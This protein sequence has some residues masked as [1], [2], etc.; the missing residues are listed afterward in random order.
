MQSRIGRGVIIA[1]VSGLAL[2]ASIVGA[3]VVG[4][5]D[6]RDALATPIGA[7]V[8]DLSSTGAYTDYGRPMLSSI[9][10][11]W[12]VDWNLSVPGAGGHR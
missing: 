9:L 7:E 5:G 12:N 11:C 4:V 8:C 2:I 1:G 6:T 3:R 10:T